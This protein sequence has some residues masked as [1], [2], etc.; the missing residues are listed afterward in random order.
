MLMLPTNSCRRCVRW[1]RINT[2][3]NQ[4]VGK[5]KDPSDAERKKIVFCLIYT[6]LFSHLCFLLGKKG[7]RVL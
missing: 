2:K 6:V 3:F 4:N 7:D 1:E 5:R